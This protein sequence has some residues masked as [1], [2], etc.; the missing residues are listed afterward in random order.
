M[1]Q[2][3]FESMRTIHSIIPESVPEPVAW[4]T[5][6]DIPDTQFFLCAFREMA[7]DMPDPLNLG[8]LLAAMHQ[9]S[10]SQTGK[11]GFHVTTYAGYLPQYV[12]REDTW[13]AFFAKSMGWALDLEIESKGPSEE[14]DRLS[15]VLF[16]RVIPRLLRPLESEGRTVKPSLVHGNLWYANPGIDVNNGQNMIFDACCLYGHNECKS[17]PHLLHMRWFETLK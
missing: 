9:K 12:G 8:A 6:T 4:G 11:F 15:R 16:D 5:Y 17:L 1:V 14:L 3:E 10:V 7:D 13:E 2:G